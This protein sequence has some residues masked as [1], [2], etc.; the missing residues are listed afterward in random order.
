MVSGVASLAGAATTA[1]AVRL[2][3]GTSAL[4]LPFQL[5]AGMS[6]HAG[7]AAVNA[8]TRPKTSS[9]AHGTGFSTCMRNSFA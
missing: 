7:S 5:A 6:V 9:N 1:A 3:A 8:A 2:S 4:T